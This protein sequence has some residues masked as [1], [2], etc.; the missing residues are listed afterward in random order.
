MVCKAGLCVK[1]NLR[2]LH[3]LRFSTSMRYAI[4]FPLIC[5]PLGS[6]T[7][8]RRKKQSNL[9]GWYYCHPSLFNQLTE[10][11]MTKKD[12]KQVDKLR[13]VLCVENIIRFAYT[14]AWIL[15][16]NL[17]KQK[18]KQKSSKKRNCKFIPYKGIT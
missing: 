15:L 9:Y 14:F 7:R 2:F 8:R 13:S 1:T 18:L 3:L 11:I 4:H 5:T 6:F 17:L 12:K 16:A 10:N